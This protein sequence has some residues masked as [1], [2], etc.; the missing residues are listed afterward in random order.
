MTPDLVSSQVKSLISHRLVEPTFHL[1][2]KLCKK[3]ER[4]LNRY[5]RTDHACVCTSCADSTHKSHDIVSTDH[6][7]KKKMVSVKEGRSRGGAARGLAAGWKDTEVLRFAESCGEEEIGA[8]TPDQGEDEETGGDQRVHQGDQGE[9]AEGPEG[10]N[11]GCDTRG[12]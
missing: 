10:A 8:Q 1:E 3:H 4:L 5:C 12:S 6:E 7:W 2:E 11:P 9:P